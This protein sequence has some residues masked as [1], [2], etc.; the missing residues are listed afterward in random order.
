ITVENTGQV[1]YTDAAPAA[2][3]DDLSDVLDDATYNADAS[4]G[5]VYAAPVLSWSG[6]LGIGETAT[7][8][9]SVTVNDPATGDNRLDNAVVTENGGNCADGSNDPACMVIIPSGS[10]TVSKAVSATSALP[11]DVVTYTVT[12]TNTGEVAY[13]TEDP[14]SF[15]DSLANVLDDAEYNDDATNGAVVDGTT[16]SWSGA[17]AVGESI[18]VTYSVTVHDAG[19]GAGDLS[20]DNVVVPTSPGGDC[21]P[22]ATCETSTPIAQFQVSKTSN[23]AG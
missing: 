13:T 15:E 16:L 21:D 23:G 2:L 1:A 19:D 9:Y 5:A 14:A 12:V 20:L 18:T 10:Y 22:A 6:A 11:G 3:T 17:L 4:G 7:I 8:T